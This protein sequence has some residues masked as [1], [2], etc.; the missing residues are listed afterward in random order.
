MPKG[1]R[2]KPA[3]TL[4]P[5]LEAVVDKWFADNFR[6]S[7]VSRDTTVYNLIHDAKATL[8]RALAEALGQT[9]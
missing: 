8:I 5:N 2:T 9:Q 4:A 1:T 7:V 6:N 3:A